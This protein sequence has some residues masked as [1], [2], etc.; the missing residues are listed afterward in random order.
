MILL[1]VD[2]QSMIVRKELFSY[3]LFVN[4]VSK[5][6]SLAR[7][8]DIEVVYIRHDDG[9][10]SELTKGKEGFEI[11]SKFSPLC[12]EKIFD[13]SY[14]S[15]FKG[16]GLHEYLK[17]KKET[18]IIVVGLQTD[19][20][21]DATIKCGFEHGYKI[22]VPSYC[23]TTVDNEFMSSEQ[24]YKYYNHKMWNKRYATCIEYDDLIS[25]L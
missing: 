11:F 13:K 25:S 17:S 22:I 19:Y 24:S 12:N 15:A 23:N 20:C 10:G 18:D 9:I 6:I 16:T 21:L 2:T 14:N 1:V 7:N 3:E 8:K 5:L 4:R